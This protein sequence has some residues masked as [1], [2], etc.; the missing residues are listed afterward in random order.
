MSKLKWSDKLSLGAP[1]IDG[2]HK[3]LVQLA[4]NLISAVRDGE[5]D[6]L[7]AFFEELMDYTEYH[8]QDEEMFMADV[9]Y[10]DLEEHRGL[11]D[12]LRAQ[13]VGYRDLCLSGECPEADDVVAFMKKW[14][15][16]HIVYSDMKIGA[17]IRKKQGDTM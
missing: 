10:P 2:Q 15:I 3:Q 8:F 17:F 6:V 16:S 5:K 11:H 9:E 7:P 1:V 12:D 4:N 14:L 13:V